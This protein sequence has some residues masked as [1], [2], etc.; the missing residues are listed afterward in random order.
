MTEALERGDLSSKE[1]LVDVKHYKTRKEAKA[2]IESK[3]AGKKDA[4]REYHRGDT[5]SYCYYF[6]GHSWIE[7]N[8]G[9]K[10]DEYYSFT[11][12]KI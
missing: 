4:R 7:E 5:P 8:T 12:T 1:E 6:T 9:E 2:F 11:L 10:R 3:L